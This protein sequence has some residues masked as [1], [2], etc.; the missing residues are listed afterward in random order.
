MAGPK[1]ECGELK[2]KPMVTALNKMSDAG[3][4]TGILGDSKGCLSGSKQEHT[5]LTASDIFN[6]PILQN[7]GWTW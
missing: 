6:I 7:C 5:Y 4:Q 1:V 2:T 3:S